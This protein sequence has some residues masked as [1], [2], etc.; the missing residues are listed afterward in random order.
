MASGKLIGG[1]PFESF[2]RMIT[3]Q[4]MTSELSPGLRTTAM[5]WI[6]SV[7]EKPL[8]VFAAVLPDFSRFNF[9]DYVS[10]G[11]AING[12]VLLQC[13]A[14]AVGFLLPVFVVGYL[15]LKMREVA[16]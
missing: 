12:D 8:A 4:N 6:D 15:F 10:C 1:G 14:R 2:N 3:Q 16:E 9:A 11:F 13:V 7:L 5:K